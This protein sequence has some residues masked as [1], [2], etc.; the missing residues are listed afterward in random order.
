MTRLGFV[1]LCACALGIPTHAQTA[2]PSVTTCAAANPFDTLPDDVALQACL[3]NFDW[4]L[5]QPDGQPGYVGYIINETIK[6]RRRGFL[7]T[8]SDNPHKVTL[9]ASTTLDGSMLRVTSV[10][11]F[12]VSFIRFDG[13]RENRTLRDKSCADIPDRNRRNVEL[14]GRNFHVR[15]VESFRALCGSA[16]TVGGSSN[17]EIYGSWFYENGSQPEEPGTVNGMW[18]DGLTVFECRNSSIRDNL[19]W[20]NTDIDLA[21]NGGAQCAVYR[22]T[23]THT[24][25][26]A[27]AGLVFGDPSVTGGEVSDNH[28]S[29]GFNLLGFGILV[30]CHPWLQCR[31]GYATNVSLHDNTVTGAVVNLAV[32]GLNGGS[33]R[34]NAPSFP[35]GTRVMNCPGAVNYALGHVINVAPLQAGYTVRIFD[36]GAPCP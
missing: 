21:V 25:K 7:L 17:F 34:D 28:V 2:S 23:I 35:Q 14:S 4:V 18:A 9:R 36:A 24:H 31:G 32:D 15:Y 10:D 3:E 22:N 8:T 20:D 5:L 30:G 11:D 29:S 1:A 6:P 19:F 26:Y 33:V 13:D 12:E 16:M 27:F